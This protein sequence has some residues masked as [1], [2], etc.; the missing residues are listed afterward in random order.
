MHVQ[1]QLLCQRLDTAGYLPE[2]EE[3]EI[4]PKGATPEI[5][6]DLASV[7][8]LIVEIN[9][10]LKK[11]N[12]MGCIIKDVEIGLVDWYTKGDKGKEVFLCWQ[13]G[14][15]S[16]NYWHEVDAGYKERKPIAELQN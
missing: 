9:E 4:D 12:E 2:G 15:K 6:H 3:I 8:L 13:L 7:K 14:E 10:Q 16:V 5:V 11:I 1:I